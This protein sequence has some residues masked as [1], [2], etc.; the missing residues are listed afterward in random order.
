VALADVD[1]RRSLSDHGMPMGR[2]S[3]FRA[4]LVPPV[5]ALPLDVPDAAAFEAHAAE[6][7]PPS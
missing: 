5:G 3:A 4:R 7:A 2:F 1:R 6:E